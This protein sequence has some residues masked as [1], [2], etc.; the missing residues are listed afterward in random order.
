MVRTDD[1]RAA[2]DLTQTLCMIYSF[3]REASCLFALAGGIIR[4]A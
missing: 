1:P 3:V 4:E 2:P